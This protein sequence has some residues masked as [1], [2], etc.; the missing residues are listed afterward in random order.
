MTIADGWIDELK[1]RVDL[2]ELATRYG[3]R[4]IRSGR[5][6]TAHCPFHEEDTASFVP[7]QKPKVGSPRFHCYGACNRSWDAIAFVQERAGV[8]FLEALQELSDLANLE[9]P[10]QSEDRKARQQRLETLRRAIDW[11]QHYFVQALQADTDAAENARAYVS[12][13]GLAAAV[14]PWGLGYAPRDNG[15]KRWLLAQRRVAEDV[16]VEAYLLQRG[17]SGTYPFQR[18]RVTVPV[19]DRSG[20]VQAH[21]GRA[22]AGQQPKYLH[23]GNII[24]VYAKGEAL[25]GLYE[26]RDVIRETGQVLL[27]EGQISAI[28]AHE[29]G[30]R[31][32]VAL[33]GSTFTEAQARRLVG[34]GARDAVFVLDG[35]EAGLRAVERALPACLAAG[36]PAR[37]VELPNG[38]DPDELLRRSPEPEPAAW[39]RDPAPAGD[40][41]TLAAGP[42]EPAQ[43]EEVEAA[44]PQ[45]DKRPQGTEPLPALHAPRTG[46]TAQDDPGV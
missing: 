41:G 1:S 28:T 26:A 21:V 27:L 33:G 16:A 30:F 15:L 10:N 20:R 5:L 38:M 18:E 36:L 39:N 12:E 34:C 32:A 4:W 37:V 19:R 43:S 25:F 29:F 7:M 44:V 6:A 3:V 11:A 45:R 31:N 35:D 2:E 9:L 13:R 23:P 14:E 17:G 24:G 46:G 22:V 40:T 8:D 42:G